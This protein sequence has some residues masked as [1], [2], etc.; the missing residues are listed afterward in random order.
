M[1]EPDL[2]KVLGLQVIPIDALFD[3]ANGPN[4]ERD[5]RDLMAKVQLI[6]G[7]DVMTRHEFL[8]FGKDALEQCVKTGKS[9]VLGGVMI[10][11]DKETDEL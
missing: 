5:P 3:E 8:V 4:T 6:F 7:R 9:L 2:E 10:E 11:L 1:D